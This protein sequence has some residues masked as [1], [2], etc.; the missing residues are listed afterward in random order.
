MEKQPHR[1]TKQRTALLELLRSTKSHPTAAWLHE[2]LA[3]EIPGLSLATV[4]RNLSVLA[5]QG[6]LQIIR[7][8][9]DAEHFDAIASSHGHIVCEACDR[10]RDLDLPDGE[11]WDREAA[12]ASG[13][14]VSSHQLIFFGICPACRKGSR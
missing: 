10:V 11:N 5:M 3:G 12:K 13:Y 8:R 1:N 7:S 4:Y 14:E 9:G 2:R 6:N